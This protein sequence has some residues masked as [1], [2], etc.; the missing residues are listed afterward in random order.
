MKLIVVLVG[1]DL[2]LVRRSGCGVALS[3][4]ESELVDLFGKVVENCADGSKDESDEEKGGQDGSGR[5][6][7]LPCFQ[8][9][10]L[11]GSVGG[12]ALGVLAQTF[13]G[14]SIAVGVVAR[15][16]ADGVPRVG[17][18][19]IPLEDGHYGCESTSAKGGAEVVER[20][21]L[22]GDCRRMPRESQRK[23]FCCKA[24]AS[25]TELMPIELDGRR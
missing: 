3:V 20:R 23:V 15:A 25:I 24:R 18:A 7:G 12:F 8:A 21:L 17:G 5:E 14:R 10:L 11:E 13:C 6:D 9:L 4:V 22:G 19:L 16:V 1:G 2:C